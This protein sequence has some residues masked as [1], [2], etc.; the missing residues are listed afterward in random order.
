MV[1][2]GTLFTNIGNI[3]QIGIDPCLKKEVSEC[4]LMHSRGTCG[5]DYPIQGKFSDIFLD[6][7][8]SRIRTEV[9]IVPTDLYP[10]QR[11][12]ETNQFLAIHSSGD[13]RATMADIDSD[14]FIHNI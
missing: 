3:E 13:V 14:F 10:G 7:I 2:P 11:A 5:D 4:G 12:G 8:L 1:N 6:E 9:T